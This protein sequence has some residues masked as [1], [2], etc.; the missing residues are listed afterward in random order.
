MQVLK[1]ACQLADVVRVCRLAPLFTSSLLRPS[2]CDILLMPSRFEPCGLNQLYAMR[3]GTVPVV[4]ATGGLR[5]RHFT[6]AFLLP[7]E[8]QRVLS[9]ARVS[10]RYRT[11]PVVHE[12][13]GLRVRHFTGTF[14]LPLRD[15]VCFLML[16]Y[17][18]RYRTVPVV[19]EAG[20]PRVTNGV[21]CKQAERAVRS[22]IAMADQ[23]QTLKQAG[24]FFLTCIGIFF[25]LVHAP[26]LLSHVCCA[27]ER[28]LSMRLCHAVL[29]MI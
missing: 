7:L 2:R 6:G 4:H 20:G 24:A 3:Y 15:S 17:A 25:H 14:L 23:G 10:M 11:V 27:E 12:T 29:S 8:G 9:H 21:E 19:R 18:M 16:V 22:D 13:G 26:F 5:V 28:G 1:F